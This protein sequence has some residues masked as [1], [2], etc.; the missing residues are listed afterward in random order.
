MVID[1]EF[2]EIDS[3]FKHK[4]LILFYSISIFNLSQSTSSTNVVISGS[5]YNTIML[6]VKINNRVKTYLLM[7]LFLDIILFSTKP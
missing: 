3:I 4:L 6:K 1:K 2:R 5:W 7:Y